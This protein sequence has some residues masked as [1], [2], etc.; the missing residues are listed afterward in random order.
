MAAEK[1]DLNDFERRM[2]G[3]IDSLKKEFTGLRTGRASIHLLDAV[4]VNVYGARMPINQAILRDEGQDCLPERLTGNGTG[5]HADPSD[6]LP[7][8]HNHCA[9]PE[10]RRLD[11]R[12]LAGRPA[13]DTQEIKIV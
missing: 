13:A 2:R 7:P 12:P 11:R 5:R 9:L 10:L 8:L 6:N 4:V 3:A 1:F